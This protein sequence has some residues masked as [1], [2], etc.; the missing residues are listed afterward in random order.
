MILVLLGFGGIGLAWSALVRIL[1]GSWR[2]ETAIICL[3]SI[4]A[5]VFGGL[6]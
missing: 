5:I 4:T 2:D 6:V 1:E 3:G